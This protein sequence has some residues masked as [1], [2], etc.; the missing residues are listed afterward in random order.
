MSR[1]TVTKKK[2]EGT[3]STHQHL[4]VQ[5]RLGNV[6]PQYNGVSLLKSRTLNSKTSPLRKIRPWR[7]TLL[8]PGGPHHD[9]TVE[10]VPEKG[11]YVPTPVS[12]CCD[13]VSLPGK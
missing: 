5:R 2:P 3:H 13:P 10:K 8:G 1:T 11:N 4:D 9:R 7:Y 6:E 12:V